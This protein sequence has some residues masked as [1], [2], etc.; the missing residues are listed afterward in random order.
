LSCREEGE[1]RG[2]K[3]IVGVRKTGKEKIR[4]EK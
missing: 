3:I 4:K 2:E 1:R